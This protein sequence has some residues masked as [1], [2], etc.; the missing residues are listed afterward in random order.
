[1][2]NQE[3]KKRLLASSPIVTV[4]SARGDLTYKQLNLADWLVESLRRRN[5]DGSTALLGKEKAAEGRWIKGLIVEFR[6]VSEDWKEVRSHFNTLTKAYDKEQR[7][8][9]KALDIKSAKHWVNGNMTVGLTAD[10]VDEAK[11]D[12]FKKVSAKKASTP[13]P[14]VSNAAFKRLEELGVQLTE[15]QMAALAAV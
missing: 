13:R 6:I 14:L 2:N 5:E 11:A 8:L 4:T 10:A 3:I 9:V 1:M 12:K 7:E 15:E